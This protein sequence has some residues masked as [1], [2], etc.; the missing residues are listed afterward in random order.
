M[1][2]RIRYR[3]HGEHVACTLYVVR[4][5]QSAMCGTF[6]LRQN[7]FD[8]FLRILQGGP[9]ECLGSLEQPHAR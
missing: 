5:E 2:F 4:G 8:E 1:T 7:E 6:A 9:I 3:K